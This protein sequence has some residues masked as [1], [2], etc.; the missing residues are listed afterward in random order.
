MSEK[1]IQKK[2]ELVNTLAEKMKN[3]N[4]F[5]IVD[6]SGLTVEQVTKL[7]VELLENDCEMAVIKNNITRR[8]AEAAGQPDVVDFLTGP[9]AVAFSNGDSVS[10]AKVVYEFA[11]ANPKLELKVG[12]VDGEF[13]DNEK[14]QTIAT[15]PTREVL[16]TMIAAGLLQPVKE[17]AIALDLMAQE[18]EEKEA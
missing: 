9:N 17:V 6:Y 7:R 16:L 13:M 12:V 8:A 2:I 3:A 5:V 14:I 4:S 1:A 11:K 10:A 18:L 15:I